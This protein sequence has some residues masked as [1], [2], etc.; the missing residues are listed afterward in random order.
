MDSGEE[1][2]GL[3]EEWSFLGAKVVEWCA[4][5]AMFIIA[6]EIFFKGDLAGSMP[7]LL[8]VWIA[9]TVSMATLRKRFPDEEKGLMNMLMVTCGFAPPG[10]PAPAEIQPLWSGAPIRY[11]PEGAEFSQLGLEEVFGVEDEDEISE[12]SQNFRGNY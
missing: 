2:Y 1:I 11:M 5:L 10:I 12:E 9:T 7:F 6:S 8:A 3:G 4:G